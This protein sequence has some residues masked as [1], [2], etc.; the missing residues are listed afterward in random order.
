MKLKF[1]GTRGSVGAGLTNEEFN[2][3]IKNIL[4]KASPED[5]KNEESIM[6]FL[7]NLPFTDRKTLGGN[8]I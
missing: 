5:I 6:N 4:T 3:K 8:G 2:A 7:E 1:W